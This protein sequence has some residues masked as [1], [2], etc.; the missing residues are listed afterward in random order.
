MSESDRDCVE[1]QRKT[2]EMCMAHAMS[3]VQLDLLGARYD[4]RMDDEA[5]C[6]VAHI[7]GYVWAEQIQDD[8]ASLT[9][10]WP[11]TVWQAFKERWFPRSW[12]RRWP[13]KLSS[14]TTVHR[15]VVK[16]T[17]PAYKPVATPQFGPIV[18]KAESPGQFRFRGDKPQETDE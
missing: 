13:V 7:Q 17:L 16:A 2:L 1:V 14:R 5:H 12:L 8:T 3:Q 15:F 18:L 11:A 6:L 10:E 4:I 9:V